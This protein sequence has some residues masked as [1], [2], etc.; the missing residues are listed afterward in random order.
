MST[1]W[2]NYF[3]EV[4]KDTAAL[5][6]DPKTKVGAVITEGKKIL[7]VG[8]NGAPS[9]F[10]D[11]LVPTSEGEGL[12]N[13]KNTFMCHAELNAILNYRGQIK[14]LAGAAVYT[15]VSPCCN[16]VLAMAQV[17]IKKVV[18]LQEYHRS[19]IHN[20]ATYIMDKCGIKYQKF[21]ENN[22]N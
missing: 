7:S 22:E 13:Q 11:E 9:S 19:E 18:Y 10:P 4:A 21:G 8:F 15:T 3:M 1:K 6:K 14:D 20:S 12:L 2:D 16:C 5:S 17:G